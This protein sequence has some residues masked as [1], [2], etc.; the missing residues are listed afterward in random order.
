MPVFA[1]RMLDVD[2]MKTTASPPGSI[3]GHECTASSPRMESGWVRVSTRPPFAETRRSPLPAAK[4][5]LSSSPQLPPRT[6]GA[7]AIT[8]GAPPARAT[9]LSFESSLKKATH[10]PSGEKKGEAAFSV[11]GSTCTSS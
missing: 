4:M 7:S 6:A 9:F 8:T 3:C 10:S 1:V 2:A 5:M 11:P